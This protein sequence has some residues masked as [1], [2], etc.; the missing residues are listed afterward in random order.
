MVKS[1]IRII[2]CI[3]ALISC[4]VYAGW[5]GPDHFYLA[6]NQAYCKGKPYLEG[7]FYVFSLWPSGRELRVKATKINSI[8]DLGTTESV[9]K[10]KFR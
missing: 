4:P 8:L 3:L 2:F 6:N 7:N 10:S 5:F 1:Y 9:D